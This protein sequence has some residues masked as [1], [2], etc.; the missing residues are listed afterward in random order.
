L[1]HQILFFLSVIKDGYRIPLL[2]CPPKICL[3]NNKSSLENSIFVEKAILDLLKGGLVKNVSNRPH[4]VNP[5]T[6]SFNGKG[7]ERLIL[8]LRHVNK[9]VRL[10][11]FKFEDWKTLKQY[12]NLNSY[13]FVF[14]L[15]SGYHHVDIHKSFQTYLGFSWELINVVKYFVFTVLPFGL[16]SSACIFSKVARPLVKLW[17]SQSIRLVLYLD[18]GFWVSDNL[19]LSS[20]QA[21][22]VKNNL[23]SSGLVPNKDN[24][25]WAPVQSLEWLGFVCNLTNC[26][27]SVPDR[28]LFDLQELISIVL[29]IVVK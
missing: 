10:D 27:L 13:G 3:S 28:K 14:D 1:G 4:V 16:K 18:D 9:H 8:D 20:R 26:T 19:Q 21:I 5:L 23:I 7:K 2:N 22:Q 6:V 17:R 15:K 25:I 24:S 12:I 11:K 29:Q